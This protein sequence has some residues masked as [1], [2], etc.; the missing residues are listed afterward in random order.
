MKRPKI[1][2]SVSIFI[3]GYHLALLIGLPFYFY[4]NS[5]ETMLYVVS[6]ILVY[7]SGLAVTVGYH[8]LYS[9]PTYK[10]NKVVEVILLFFGSMATQGSALS[11]SH[12]HR[13]H[14]AYVDTNRDPYS[15]KKGFMYAHVLWL[16]RKTPP[17]EKKVV[18]D[19]YRNKL[20]LFQHKYF[21]P[22]MI[23]TNVIVTAF[24][25]FIFNDYLGALVLA[26]GVRLFFLHHLT[27]FINSLAHTWGSQSFSQEH[28]AVDN[29][30]I[31][32]LTF[33]E[34]YHNYHHT[35]A[36]DYR[37]GVKW[38]HFDPTKWIIWT[39]HKCKLA[40]DLKR[41][42][43]FQAKERMVIERK[44]EISHEIKQFWFVHK[45][46]IEDA[47]ESTTES[48]LHKLSDIR[49]LTSEYNSSK[50]SNESKENLERL[51]IKIK[52]MK[53]SLKNDWKSW[54]KF[55]KAVMRLKPI[56]TSAS[57]S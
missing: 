40:T 52:D 43:P 9:H 4:H 29:Y 56:P 19:L 5:P 46:A 57:R 28:S 55:S 20:V 30:C 37:N 45:K 22:L 26:W 1:E 21:V 24:V 49:K 2:W 50:K 36:N 53:K 7:I 3:I 13:N 32:L 31:S 34:G 8:R 27:W 47:V 18:A 41:V 12:G 51:Y 42:S 39:L 48:L 54:K 6:A 38:Y 11:W 44:N 10:T 17:I 35:Y 16:F 25:G 14:H 15:I 33:G 23:L